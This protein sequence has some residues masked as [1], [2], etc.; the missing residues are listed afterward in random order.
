MDKNVQRKAGRMRLRLYLAHKYRF[1]T[2]F[3]AD[4]LFV[5]TI[6]ILSAMQI[7]MIS[8]RNKKWNENAP[9]AVSECINTPIRNMFSL[10]HETSYQMFE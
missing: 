10:I 8:I 3:I 1:G 6:P 5:Y 9:M 2:I 4:S 7:G